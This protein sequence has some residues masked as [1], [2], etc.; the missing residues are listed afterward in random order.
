MIYQHKVAVAASRTNRETTHII[1]VKLAS[2]LNP[3]LELL[4]IDGGKLDGDVQKYL[5]EIG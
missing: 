4:E 3:D 2:G 1:G 5:R